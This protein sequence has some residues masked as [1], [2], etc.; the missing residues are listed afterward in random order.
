MWLLLF[1]MCLVRGDVFVSP[2]GSDSNDGR[3]AASPLF[4]L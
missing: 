1:T 4:T 2:T 3:S